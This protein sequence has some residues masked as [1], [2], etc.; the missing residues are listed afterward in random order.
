M[1][2]ILIAEDKDSLRGLLRRILQGQGELTF[3]ADGAAAL[4]ALSVGEFDVVL[5]D[6]RMPGADGLEVLRAARQRPSPPVVILMTAYATVQSAIEAIR[7][8]AWDYLP[9]PFEPDDVL[10][11][12]RRALEHKHLRDRADHLAREVRE[13]YAFEQLL[14][15][16][17][18]MQRVFQLLEKAADRDLTVLVT[19]ES[20]TGK[21]LA[22][23]AVHYA[24]ARAERPFVAVNC[25]AFPAELMESELFGHAR[26]A[27]TGATGDKRGL[28][29]AAAGGT[30]FLDEVGDLPL[31][32]QVKLNRALQEREFRRVG[33]TTARKVEARVI[34]AT[35]VDLRAAIAEGRFREDLFYRLNVFPVRLPSL[36]ER[37]EDVPLLASTFLER[38]RGRASRGPTGF[39][40]EASRAMLAYAWPGNV[41]ELENA[42]ERAAAVA[43]GE[44][45]TRDDLPPEVSEA[46]A[47]AALPGDALAELPYREAVELI[48][49]RATTDYLRALMRRAGGNVSRAAE[50][51][52]LARESLHRLLK[53]HGVEADRFRPD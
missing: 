42:I 3:A 38:A 25:G 26:G 24:S 17:P 43:D 8:G 10:V 44:L 21:E 4:A 45:V 48:R 6:L 46:A 7:E 36:R 49:D 16:S 14:G 32:L 53:K 50:Q 31:P 19:G 15:K 52:G 47:P 2:R 11:R 41:R 12:V 22:A 20:G 1:S 13:R 5:S 18:A 30:L 34:A 29:E 23:R 9:K 37:P 27:F 35:N 39:A 40:P 33:E 28:I 51:A